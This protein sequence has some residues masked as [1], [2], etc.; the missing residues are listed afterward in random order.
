MH[1]NKIAQAAA[2]ALTFAAVS[3][4][5]ATGSMAKSTQTL[6]SERTIGHIE[7]VFEFYGAMPTGDDPTSIVVRRP[8]T[9]STRVTVSSP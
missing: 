2:I 8:V 5:H 6:A 1:L 7:P 4:A 9:A 3:A